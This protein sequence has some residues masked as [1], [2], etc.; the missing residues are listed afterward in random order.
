MIQ[1][2]KSVVR[3][4]IALFG[5]FFGSLQI[6]MS[7]CQLGVLGPS[8]SGWLCGHH[9]PQTWLLLIPILFI[10]LMLILGNRLTAFQHSI[11]VALLFVY[12]S[13]GVFDSI[14]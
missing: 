5:A 2:L 8:W 14:E 9:V 3:V 7:G 10:A 6:Q 1:G 4:L 13:Y 12:G 11:C